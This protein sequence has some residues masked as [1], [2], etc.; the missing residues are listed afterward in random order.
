MK[1]QFE[2]RLSLE[3]TAT[4]WITVPK[5]ALLLEAGK[6][7]AIHVDPRNLAIGVHVEFVKV[8]NIIYTYRCFN[9]KIIL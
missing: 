8:C 4:S 5:H 1:F 9:N 6:S 2:M 7:I 3:S